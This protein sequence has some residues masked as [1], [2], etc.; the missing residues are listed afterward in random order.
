MR[1]THRGAHGRLLYGLD[2]AGRR[3]GLM[4]PDFAPNLDDRS[5]E[6]LLAEATARIDAHEPRSGPT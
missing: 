4:P 5:F 3:P 2:L 6:Q 1:A